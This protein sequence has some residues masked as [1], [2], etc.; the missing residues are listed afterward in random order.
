MVTAVQQG[1]WQ[2]G[3]WQQPPP[4]WGSPTAAQGMST[5]AKVAIAIGALSAL[6]CVG[7]MLAPSPA[8]TPPP[9]SAQPPMPPPTPMPP[10]E[11]APVPMVCPADYGEQVLR[12]IRND[13]CD[14]GRRHDQCPPWVA[15]IAGIDPACEVGHRSIVVRTVFPARSDGAAEI[16]RTIGNR[17]YIAVLRDSHRRHPRVRVVA[18]NGNVLCANFDG[19]AACATSVGEMF[20]L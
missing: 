1:P 4:G 8:P 9:A 10:D 20:G 6:C 17:A 12:Q 3:P 13:S 7:G 5:G 19:S 15:A 16:A 18:A 11:S 2:Q 14:G